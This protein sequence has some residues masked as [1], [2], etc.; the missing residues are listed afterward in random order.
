MNKI[1]K[2]IAT[3]FNSRKTDKDNNNLYSG[4]HFTTNHTGKMQGM[5]SLSTSVLQNKN[6]RE[7]AKNPLTICSK[8]YASKMMH[9]YKDLEKNLANNT[10]ILTSEIIPA[11]KLPYIN[12]HSF[13]FEAFGDLN[14]AIQVINYFN[15]CRKNPACNFAIWTKNPFIIMNAIR[16][17]YKK[18]ANLIIIYSSPFIDTKVTL[19]EIQKHFPFV[20]KVFTV[21]SSEETAAANNAIINCGTRKCIECLNCYRK[22]GNN[23]ISELLK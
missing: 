7:R 13:R 6:C 5:Y 12:A 14:N 8:C 20:D 11:E 21:Y 22:T 9:M 17:G 23:E 2:A 10:K 4:L 15:I 16:D 19:E 3:M 18:P 1:K